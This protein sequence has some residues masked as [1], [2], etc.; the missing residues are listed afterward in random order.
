MQQSIQLLIDAPNTA[1]NVNNF[2]KVILRQECA[3]AREEAKHK[4]NSA[5]TEKKAVTLPQAR[6]DQLWRIPICNMPSHAF[7]AHK[8]LMLLEDLMKFRK[9]LDSKIPSLQTR[10]QSLKGQLLEERH[11]MADTQKTQKTGRA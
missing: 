1:R 3:T 4:D 11:Q 8:M 2:S 6:S 9:L 10:V 7:S 5:L